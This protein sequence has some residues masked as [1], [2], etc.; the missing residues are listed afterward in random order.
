MSRRLLAGLAA[1]A[2]A[3]AAAGYLVGAGSSDGDTC[4]DGEL[5]VDGDCASIQPGTPADR[6]TGPVEHIASVLIDSDPA[7]GTLSG[8]CAFQ[9]VADGRVD[10]YLCLMTFLDTPITFRILHERDGS[11]YEWRVLSDP[12]PRRPAVTYPPFHARE[13]GRCTYRDLQPDCE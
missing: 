11:V 3:V 10:V 6:T 13:S 1:V 8:R 4:A 12:Q 7:A 9:G 5:R 2:V